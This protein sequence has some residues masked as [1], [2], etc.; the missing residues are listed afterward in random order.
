ML[1]RDKYRQHRTSTSNVLYRDKYNQ[2]RYTL[3]G[4]VE[5]GG[6]WTSLKP[7]FQACIHFLAVHNSLIGDLAPWSVALSDT[8]NNQRVLNTT[9]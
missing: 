4:Q 1:P 7:K 5:S 8:T 6:T 9:E 2:I 3:Q